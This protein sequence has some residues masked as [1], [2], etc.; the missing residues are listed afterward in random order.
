MDGEKIFLQVASSAS[1]TNIE[2]PYETKDVDLKHAT[3]QVKR[4]PD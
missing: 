2:L 4:I 3:F 1:T